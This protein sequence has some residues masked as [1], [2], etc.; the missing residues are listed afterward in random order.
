MNSDLA[1]LTDRRARRALTA[2]ERIRVSIER[3]RPPQLLLHR[4]R[5][6]LG[7]MVSDFSWCWTQVRT[8]AAAGPERQA[9]LAEA[10]TIVMPTS[11][12]QALQ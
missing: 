1:G 9:S 3:P 11:G 8:V 10:D 5:S 7:Q 6:R 4:C 2:V 12:R